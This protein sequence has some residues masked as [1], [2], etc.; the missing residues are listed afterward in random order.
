MF[1]TKFFL[2][3]TLR[4]CVSRLFKKRKQFME[5]NVA[6][7]KAKRD[8]FKLQQHFRNTVFFFH[9]A[10]SLSLITVYNCALRIVYR[11]NLSAMTKYITK[12]I[13]VIDKSKPFS[14]LTI[15]G[16]ELSPINYLDKWP[17]LPASLLVPFGKTLKRDSPF[18]CGRQMA[19]NS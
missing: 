13:S 3:V 11:D 7:N 5:S 6:L 9:S 4:K 19:G 18:W 14:A 15:I 2:Q 12:A 10:N 16:N 17:S 8:V 1:L